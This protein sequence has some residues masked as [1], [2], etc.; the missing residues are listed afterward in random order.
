VNPDVGRARS[1]FE[2]GAKMDVP[3][4]RPRFMVRSLG[5]LSGWIDKLVTYFSPHEYKRLD[6][7]VSLG[8]R[9][10]PPLQVH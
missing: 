3:F 7:F 4:V 1:V 10:L 6:L 8:I 9:P 2:L 5:P